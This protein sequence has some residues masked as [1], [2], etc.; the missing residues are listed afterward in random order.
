M[1]DAMSDQFIAPRIL[2]CGDTGISVEFGDIIDPGLNA[3]VRRLFRALRDAQPVGILDL[4][5]TYR[6]LFIEYDPFEC[7][8]ERLALLVDAAVRGDAEASLPDAPVI[9][10]PVCYGGEYGPD[11]E[12]VAACHQMSVEEVIELHRRPIYT[13]YMIG[14]TPG[15]P[16]LGGLDER[17]IT[18][19]KKQPRQ[20]VPAGSVGIADR[21]TGIYSTDS[22]GGWQIIGRTPVKLF[23]LTRAEPFLLQ[24][25]DRVQF[26]AVSKEAFES[27]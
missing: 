17:L 26:I 20:R 3:R 22:P 6:A 1:I 18:P 27:P 15:F 5:P 19:R 14:F 24:A 7:S 8:L 13:V 16:Y 25:W 12:E 2:P 4:I 21:Q 9:E 23:D 11:L 10:I